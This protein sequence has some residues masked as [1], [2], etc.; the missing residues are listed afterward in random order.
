M[1]DWKPTTGAVCHANGWFALFKHEG[2][3]PTI[4]RVVLWMVGE[5]LAGDD[6]VL[7]WLEGYCSGGDEGLIASTETDNFLRFVYYADPCPF[8]DKGADW[9]EYYEVQ[10]QAI[11]DAERKDWVEK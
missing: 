2:E 11:A 1:T 10:E 7:A 6:K 4:D 8:L 9:N 3:K 5:F